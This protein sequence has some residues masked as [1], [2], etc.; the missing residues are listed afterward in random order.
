MK[1]KTV[2]AN[3]LSKQVKSK[4][5]LRCHGSCKTAPFKKDNENT[6]N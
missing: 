6:C 1:P 3:F 4:N 2:Q 5:S